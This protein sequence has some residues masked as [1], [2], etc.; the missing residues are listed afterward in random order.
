MVRKKRGAP[1]NNNNPTG[2]GGF[3]ER[4][5]QINLS[6]R[7]KKEESISYQYHM[8]I[9][10]TVG[11]FKTW[12]KKYSESKRTMAQEL[13]YQ[14]VLAART[15]IRYLEEVTDRTE[16]KAPQTI[17]HDGELKNTFDD[18]QI[19]RIAERIAGRKR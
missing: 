1:G 10:F 13:A 6:G 5:H 16:G 4:R 2:K 17:T 19:N 3:G 14:A 18:D 15:D 7:W 11:K 12:L 8:L 9:R